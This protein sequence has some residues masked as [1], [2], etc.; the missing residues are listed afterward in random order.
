[1]LSPS[2]DPVQVPGSSD[3]AARRGGPQVVD[4]LLFLTLVAFTLVLLDVASGWALS[5]LFHLG[6]GGMALMSA[7]VAV[8]FGYA[9]YFLG[10]T[11]LGNIGARPP[12]GG[13]SA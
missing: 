6:K 9:G 8:P 3:S 7:V 5:G 1:M 12:S 11:A 2:G 10:R 13:Q 4:A